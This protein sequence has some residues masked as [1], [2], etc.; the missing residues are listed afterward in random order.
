METV[1]FRF[2]PPAPVVRLGTAVS[3]A[4]SARDTAESV[5]GSDSLSR[6]TELDRPLKGDEDAPETGPKM[7]ATPELAKLAKL[8]KLA[9]TSALP[10]NHEQLQFTKNIRK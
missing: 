9:R 7:A 3:T 5:G 4:T 10:S 2:L 1:V 8:A 6:R